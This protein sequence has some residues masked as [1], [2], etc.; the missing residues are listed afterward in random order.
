MDLHKV[1]KPVYYFADVCVH[2]VHCS[3]LNMGSLFPSDCSK[4][5]ISSNFN[6]WH[7]IHVVEKLP[8][9]YNVDYSLHMRSS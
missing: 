6:R 4:S 3:P 7:Y 9:N 5:G 2:V 1:M 8:V